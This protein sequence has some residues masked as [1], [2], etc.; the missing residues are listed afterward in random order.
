MKVFGLDFTSSPTKKKPLVCAH[1]Y[2]RSKSELEISKLELWTN[3][4]EFEEFLYRNGPWIAGF[5]FPFGLPVSFLKNNGLP[6]DWNNYVNSLAKLSK[7]ELEEHVQKFKNS[8]PKGLKDL[9]RITDSIHQA[10]SPLKTVNPPLIKMFYEGAKRLAKSGVSVVPFHHPKDN[11]IVFETY[12]ALLSRLFTSNYKS[13]SNDSDIKRLKLSRKKILDG[14]LSDYLLINL[15]FSL[16][17]EDDVKTRIIEDNTG[18]SLDSVLCCIQAYWSFL[19]GWPNF[20]ITSK[21]QFTVKAEGWIVSPHLP[22]P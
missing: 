18:D 14:V 20:G 17:I 19:Q 5:D 21:N 16:S 7:K 4:E 8:Q 11:R 10:Q 22:P 15:G 13:D 3:F 1:G 9:P 2:G 6:L 12:P